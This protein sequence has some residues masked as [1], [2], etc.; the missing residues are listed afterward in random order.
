MCVVCCVLSGRGLYDEI[1][2]RPEESCR[3][4][5]FVAYDLECKERGGHRKIILQRHMNILFF[6]IF[7]IIR[8]VAFDRG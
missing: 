7:S 1:I 6:V 4:C 5:C 3:V 2:T 8:R